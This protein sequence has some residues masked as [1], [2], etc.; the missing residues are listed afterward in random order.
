MEFPVSTRIKRQA[1]VTSISWNVWVSQRQKNNQYEFE[2]HFC[3]DSFLRHYRLCR[4]KLNFIH[5]YFVYGKYRTIYLLEN[6]LLLVIQLQLHLLF[7]V[8]RRNVC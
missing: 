6:I 4:G 7:R 5:F 1:N 8:Q 3:F 2:V